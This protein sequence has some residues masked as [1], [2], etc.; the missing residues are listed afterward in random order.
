MAGEPH[1]LWQWLATTAPPEGP[2]Q[3]FCNALRARL[4]P[5]LKSLHAP[6]DAWLDSLPMSVALGSILALFAFTAVWVWTLR[7][8]YV[9]LGAPDQ[10]RWRDLRLWA[11]LLLIPYVVVYV[12]LGR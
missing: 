3:R 6:L 12:A 11:T 5:P 7:R 1:M 10:A 9:Y 2:W 8:D 4:G